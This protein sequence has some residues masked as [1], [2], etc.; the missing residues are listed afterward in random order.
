MDPEL[1]RPWLGEAL[2]FY[3]EA[4]DAPVLVYCLGSTSIHRN[5]IDMRKLDQSRI[6]GFQLDPKT[7]AELTMSRWKALHK[8]RLGVRLAGRTNSL[9]MA[10]RNT[11]KSAERPQP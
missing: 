11:P 9:L 8:V 10:M 7:D 5:V 6:I 3:G 4:S 2:E 1:V